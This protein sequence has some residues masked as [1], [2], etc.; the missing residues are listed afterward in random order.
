MLELSAH[1]S[2]RSFR[3][4]A[5]YTA[6]RL[7][8]GEETRA[9]A[10]D[11]EEAVDHLRLLEDEQ[12]RLDQRRVQTQ[13]SLEA[14]DDAWDDEMNALHQRLLDLSDS[15][16][17]S[18]LYRRYFADIPSHV[19]ELSL[20]AEVMISAQLERRL[21]EDPHPEIEPFAERLGQRRAA[22]EAI[23]N[24]SL[25]LEV[26]EARFENRVSMA[27]AIVNKLRR[28]LLASLEELAAARDHGR[29]W[30]ARF[31]L[32]HEE[33]VHALNDPDEGMH[34]LSDGRDPEDD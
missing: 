28:V 16:V 24:E 10:R 6:A 12:A 29:D 3:I 4:E 5:S 20:G 21:R 26:D 1:G 2:L 9:L 14:A 25:A 31:Y 23:M 18:E 15:D 34:L 19:T 13:A 27:K 8:A 22:L 11:F 17:D 32:D 7:A 33:V 30:C